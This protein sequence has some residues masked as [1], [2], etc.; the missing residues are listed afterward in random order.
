MDLKKI[1]KIATIGA[2]AAGLAG[3]ATHA[4]AAEHTVNGAQVNNM[5]KCYGVAKAGKNDCGVPGKHG[6]AAQSKTDGGA[7]DWVMAPKGLCDKLVNGST[8]PGAANGNGSSSNG[9]QS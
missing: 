8:T 5:E 7:Q 9:S 4:S 6:C 1:I 2:A 3:L